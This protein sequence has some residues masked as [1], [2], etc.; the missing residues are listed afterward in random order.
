MDFLYFWISFKFL[1]VF[2]YPP[3]FFD[4]MPILFNFSLQFATPPICSIFLCDFPN[5][6]INQYFFGF[7]SFSH[8]FPILFNLFKT[9]RY[10]SFLIG[11]FIDLFYSLDNMDH[12]SIHSLK[13]RQ[14]FVAIGF[15]N[16]FSLK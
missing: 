5:F 16:S 9:L 8:Y 11:F 1:C 10:F 6:Y 15:V 3:N 7:Y 2:V 4:I 12:L 14:F 13:Y